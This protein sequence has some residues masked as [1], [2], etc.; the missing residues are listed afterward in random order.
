MRSRQHRLSSTHLEHRRSVMLRWWCNRIQV[1]TC[2]RRR[3]VSR[4]CGT[5]MGRNKGLETRRADQRC[6]NLGLGRSH[7]RPGRFPT[8]KGSEESLQSSHNLYII[9]KVSSYFMPVCSTH[10]KL[11]LERH[12]NR[13]ETASKSLNYSNDRSSLLTVWAGI[14]VQV[15]R[16]G[17]GCASAGSRGGQ[18]RC[19]T[20]HA[21]EPCC[22]WLTVC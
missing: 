6:L 3:P 7:L 13:S 21:L 5:T 17:P 19:A 15:S 18:Y 2:G 4:H 10:V 8:S 14:A 16:S 22:T 12:Q 1:G 11:L 20:N 9:E